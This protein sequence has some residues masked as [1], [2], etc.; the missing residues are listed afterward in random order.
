M[1]ELPIR[2]GADVMLGADFSVREMAA[3]F[4][5]FSRD[6]DVA[7]FLKFSRIVHA[8]KSGSLKGG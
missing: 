1:N 2:S 7:S 6:C 4:N 5:T 8:V 3:F